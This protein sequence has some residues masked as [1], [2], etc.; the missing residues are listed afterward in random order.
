MG[1][2]LS[3]LYKGCVVMSKGISLGSIVIDC[4][5]AGELRDFYARL[6]G[7]EAFAIEGHPVLRSEEGLLLLFVEA[8]FEYERPVWPEAPG[9]QQKQIHFDFHVD[10]LPHAV[11]DAETLGARKSPAQFGGQRYVTMFDHEGHPFCLCAK[12]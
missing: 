11:A 9:R 8:D 3:T 2:I 7:W 12:E 4:K 5:N 10:D 6:L 1:L